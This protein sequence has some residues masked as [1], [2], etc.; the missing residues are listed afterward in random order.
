[1]IWDKQA[2]ELSATDTAVPRAIKAVAQVAFGK[3][4]GGGGKGKKVLGA[5][6][7]GKS[8]S[9]AMDEADDDD[10]EEDEEDEDEKEGAEAGKNGFSDSDEDDLDDLD[11]EV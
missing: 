1:M 9:H 6:A 11:A 10:G 7:K 4:S 8:E 5:V 3:K 2:A